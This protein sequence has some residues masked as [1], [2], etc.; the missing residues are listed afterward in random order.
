[1]AELP[2]RPNLDQLR[3]QSRDL[4][5]SAQKGD[6]EALGRIRAVSDRLSLAASQLAVARAYG[7]ASWTR[8]KREVDRRRILNERDLAR[9]KALLAEEPALASSEMEHWRD[10]P[11]GVRPLN[12]VAMLAFDADR[13]GLPR[14]PSGTGAVG[15][16]LLEAGAPVN[17]FPGE[18]ETPLI[19]AASYGDVEVALVLIQAGADLEARAA[20]DAGGVPGG[21]A[22]LHAAV[23]GMTE[24]VD[25]LA[26][27]GA[28]IGS[29]EEAAAAGN[30]DGWLTPQTPPEAKVRALVMAADHQRLRVIDQLLAAG[31]PLDAVDT[32]WGRQALCV[33]AQNGRA[34]AV[35]HLLALGADPNARDGSGLTPLDYCRPEHRSFEG[36]ADDPV[37]SILRSAGARRTSADA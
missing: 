32:Q 22:L 27:A 8:L 34:A 26:A 19:T 10:H 28:R 13:L 18:P 29:L 6:A 15:R 24:V 9:L 23:F 31:A 16:A 17:G 12:Y 2:A 33:S 3:H 25:A 14:Q 36:P 37:E 1:M 35:R 21:T 11:K 20:P 30:L 4:L 5:R 7:F